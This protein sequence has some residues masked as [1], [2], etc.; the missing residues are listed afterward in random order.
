MT[1]KWG[2]IEGIFCDEADPELIEFLRKALIRNGYSI[3][4]Y[5]SIKI[6]ISSRIHLWGILLMQDRIKF[7]KN[8]TEDIV[9]GL[10]EATQDAEADDDRYLDDNTSC[11]DILDA[12]CYGIERWYKQLLRIGG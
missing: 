12:Q 9:K 3:P 6:P 1:K 10:Q 11:I 8:E 5:K 4:I 2:N 7:V